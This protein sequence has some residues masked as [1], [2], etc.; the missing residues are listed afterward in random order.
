MDPKLSKNSKKVISDS[1]DEAIRLKNGHIGVEHLFLGIIREQECSAYIML[2]QMGIDLQSMKSRIESAIGRQQSE[3]VFSD[4]SQIPMLKQTEKVLRLAFLESTK[5]KKPEIKTEHLV[6]AILMEGENVAARLLDREGL[7]YNKFFEALKKEHPDNDNRSIED[8]YNP[9]LDFGENDEEDEDDY[10]YANP[11]SPKHG[12]SGKG[13][14]TPALENFGRDLTKAAE[15][16]RLDPIVGRTKELERI[17][18]ILSRRKKNNPVL[19]G[20]PGVGKSAIAE[21]LAQRIVEGKVPSTL[22]HKRVISLDLASLVAGT[23]Y[24]GQFEERMKAI[25]NEL[26]NNHNIILFIDEIHTIVGAGSASGSLDASNMFKPALARGEIQCIGATTLDEYRQYIEKDGALE[27]RFQ[28]VLVEASSAEETY[29]ILSNIRDKYEDHHMVHY[30][31]EALRACIS[32]TERYVSERLLPDKAIDA[33]DEAG[34]RVRIA[35]VRVPQE[36]VDMEQRIAAVVQQKKTVLLEKRYNEAAALRDEERELTAELEKMRR[37][38]ENEERDHRVQVT[39][40]DVAEVVAMMTGVPVQRIAQNEGTR[41][42]NMEK[43]LEGSVIGQDEAIKKISKAIRRNRAGL[44]DPNKPIGTFIFLGPTGVGKTYLTKVLA[45]YL[46]DSEQAMIRIDMS[47]YMD[48]YDVSRLIGAP[49]GYVGYE[50]GG[51]LTEKVRRKPYSIILLDEIE[52]A[53]PDIFNVLLQVLD[54]GQLTDGLGRKVDFKNTII[55]MTSNI[56]SR[57]LKDFGTG[58]GFNTSARE[59]EKSVMERDVIEKALKKSFAPEFLNRIDDIIYFNSLKRED[60]HKIIE[61]ELKGLFKRIRTMGFEIKIDDKAKDFLVAKGWDAQYGARPLK[62]AIQRY[63]EDDLAEEIIK[64][65]IIAGDTI[66]ITTAKEEGKDSPT[67]D[68]EKIVFEIEKGQASRQLSEVLTESME[69]ECAE[70][71]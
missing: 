41:L 68:K 43:E 17:A 9:N 36:I 22:Y 29:E 16:G 5:L 11:E 55:I 70:M 46:F 23:K 40:N 34:A 49:P 38:F 61:I 66:C 45:K 13:N 1:R 4:E 19:I 6:L 51:Q 56:G 62:R 32:L 44:K 31:D 24:R 37:A 35:N 50:E 47:E 65:D 15:E 42:L 26:E 52:K 28:K 58:V 18:Q 3:E 59:A 53:H 7:T 67:L 2:T 63:I 60:I 8:E 14:K 30:T 39:E 25:L 64:A 33:M 48:K 27:R 57:Q 21:G 12:D 10:P 71:E 69:K 20:E 54:D